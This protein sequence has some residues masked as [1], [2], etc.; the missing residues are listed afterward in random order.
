MIHPSK[1]SQ[2]FQCVVCGVWDVSSW[3][4]FHSGRR[5]CSGCTQHCAWHGLWPQ[6]AT[7]GMLLDPRG[8]LYR[9]ENP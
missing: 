7:K 9:P 4:D 1:G 3:T 6:E 5:Q 8:F 2:L